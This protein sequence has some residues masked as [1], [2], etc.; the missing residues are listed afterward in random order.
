MPDQ[1][2]LRA[3]SVE[4]DFACGVDRHFHRGYRADTPHVG[5]KPRL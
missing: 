4:G 1:P 5:T 3:E 2:I